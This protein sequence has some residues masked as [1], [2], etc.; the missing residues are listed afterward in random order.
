MTIDKFVASIAGLRIV[1]GCLEITAAIIMLVMNEPGRAL[2]I[3]TLLALVGPLILITTT[4][5]G[6]LGIAD[7]LNWTKIAWI[8]AGVACLLMG[9]M[10]K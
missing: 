5:I 7:R 9:M 6:L 1:S 3:N 10:K 2:A 8:G 4:T